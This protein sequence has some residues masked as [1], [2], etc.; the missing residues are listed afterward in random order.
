MGEYIVSA[1]IV[2]AGVALLL[3]GLYR[4]PLL[5]VCFKSLFLLAAQAVGARR[6]MV[7]VDGPSGCRHWVYLEA[8]DSQKPVMVLLH[9]FGVD[10]Y[11]WLHYVKAFKHEYHIIVPDLPGFGDAYCPDQPADY[12]IDA[13]VSGLIC[14]LDT[15]GIEDAHVAGNSMGGMIAARFSLACP[16]RVKTLV[17]LNAAGLQSVN[18]SGLDRMYRDGDIALLPETADELD[19]LLNLVSAR[20]VRLPRFIKSFILHDLA[21]RRS[22]LEQAFHDIMVYRHQHP[23][24]ECLPEI[25]VPTL[26]IWGQQDGLLDAS[27]AKLAADSLPDGRYVVLENTGHAPMVESPSATIACHR[28]LLKTAEAEG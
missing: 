20:P 10:K 26:I 3:I 12:S 28:A 4:N 15:L 25:P 14:F 17:L 21:L 19:T 22:S 9:G 11:V 16:Q 5:S 8:G 2:A 23:L 7:S 27:A 18:E 13:Q 1:V 6:R 24:N